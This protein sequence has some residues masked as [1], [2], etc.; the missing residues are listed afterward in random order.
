L[1][2][3]VLADLPRIRPVTIDADLLADLE[4]M[5]VKK[6][7]GIKYEWTEERDAI[8]LKYWKIRN[9]RDVVKVLGCSVN[10]AL[11]R[12]RELTT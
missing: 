4:A 1:S 8:L 9:H 10:T 3:D 2:S 7:Q 5:P 12:Y 6:Q 11:D